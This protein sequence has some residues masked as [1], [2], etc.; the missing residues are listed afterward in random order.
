MVVLWCSWVIFRV[1]L[2]VW[3][4]SLTQNLFPNPHFFSPSTFLIL[5]SFISSITL[6]SSSLLSFQIPL[7]YPHPSYLKPS[8]PKTLIPNFQ[9]IFN[10]SIST[11]QRPNSG[12]D[13][14]PC[15]LRR[16]KVPKELAPMRRIGE[17]SNH[18]I[19]NVLSNGE[20]D[21]RYLLDPNEVA[22]GVLGA[23][24][25]PFERLLDGF[26]VGFWWVLDGFWTGF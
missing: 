15:F 23:L 13:N 26:L 14:V 21:Y 9:S 3:S 2:K 22:S 12:R 11:L 5:N 1:V 6:P 20:W 4:L 25:V 7:S 17:S 19:L 8:H 24:V 18:S 16:S 10:L